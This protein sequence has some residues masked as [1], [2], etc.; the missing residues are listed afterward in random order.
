[1]REDLKEKIKLTKKEFDKQ[2]ED[3]IAYQYY[4]WGKQDHD[5]DRWLV[6]LTEEVGEAC[7]AIL[8]NDAIK[9]RVELI[10]VAAVIESWLVRKDQDET[11]NTRTD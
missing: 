1:M 10:Q 4:K 9:A 6:I 2:I 8:N 5:P 11:R 7:N 3:E